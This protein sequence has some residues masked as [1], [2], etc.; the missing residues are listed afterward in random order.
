MRP[1][2]L[3][4]RLLQSLKKALVPAEAW[5]DHD[6][7]PS[8]F[9]TAT[10]LVLIASSG[11]L[12]LSSKARYL[13]LA[14]NQIFAQNRICLMMLLVVFPTVCINFLDVV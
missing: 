1:R 6:F 3:C 4:F 13:M 7:C 10:A 2:S 9:A 8:L 14:F 5:Q 12:L 11:R